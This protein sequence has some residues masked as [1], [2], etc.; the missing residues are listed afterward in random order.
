[1]RPAMHMQTAERQVELLR[2]REASARADVQ[3]YKQELAAALDG[4]RQ[5]LE[6]C[7][8]LRKR[9]EVRDRADVGARLGGDAASHQ[10]LLPLTQ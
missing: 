8:A 6:Q 5:L 10:E 1:M 3:G 2:G 7:Q 4:N 9:A